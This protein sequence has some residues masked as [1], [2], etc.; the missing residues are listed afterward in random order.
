MTKLPLL[1]LA[2]LVVGCKDKAPAKGDGKEHVGMSR[3]R[4]MVWPPGLIA[5]VDGS[6]PK[7]MLETVAGVVRIGA[8]GTPQ[9]A[10]VKLTAGKPP[11]L[12]TTIH[13][14]DPMPTSNTSLATLAKDLGLPEIAK[15]RPSAFGAAGDVGSGSA[16]SDS[17]MAVNPTDVQFAQ[18][19]HPE[20]ATSVPVQTPRLSSAFAIAHP[21]D[22]SAGIVVVAEAKAPAT[23]LVDVLA[24]T[25]GFIAVKR[26]TELG[27]L[28][29]AFDRQQ[30]P[31]AAPN[32]S[33]L[34]LRLGKPSLIAVVPGLP[35]PSDM[36]KITD[37]IKTSGMKAVDI[38][39]AADSTVGDLVAAIELARTSGIDA[40]G[41]GRVPVPNTP[42][43]MTRDYEGPR[44]V[45]WDFFM[46]NMDKTD[47]TPFRKAFDSTVEPIHTCYGKAAANAPK[48]AI[49]LGGVG[50]VELVVETTGKVSDLQTTGIAS[51][52]ATCTADALKAATF[53]PIATPVKITAQLAFVPG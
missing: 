50:R 10:T 2:L 37:V 44:V 7:V 34:E 6:G 20:P 4:D 15:R 48:S 39:V 14:N 51:P 31:F 18:L 23:A 26:G 41:L 38:L 3:G 32:R 40:I 24:I 45:A 47:V 1:L 29:F 49:G 43:T 13:G 42:A 25:G 46:Q 33:W 12:E 27:A 9:I 21:F 28:P 53:P 17:A 35:M 19:G 11:A 16:G 52:L 8:D 22:V 30:P 5:A 36:N